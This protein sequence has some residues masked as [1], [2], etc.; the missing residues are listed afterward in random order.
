MTSSH[1]VK[2]FEKDIRF[3]YL[4]E[5]L[6]SAYGFDGIMRKIKSDNAPKFAEVGHQADIVV[7][8]IY[9]GQVKRR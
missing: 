7:G 9:V 4:L 8:K 3:N 6:Q 1:F 5:I 2:E